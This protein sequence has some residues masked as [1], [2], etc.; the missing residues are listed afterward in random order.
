MTP[1]PQPNSTHLIPQPTSPT[2][3]SLN[4]SGRVH[5]NTVSFWLLL[6]EWT[7][8]CEDNSYPSTSKRLWR[9]YIS[10]RLTEHPQE[11]V[12]FRQRVLDHRTGVPLSDISVIAFQHISKA[13]SASSI[14]STASTQPFPSARPPSVSTASNSF[15]YQHSLKIYIPDHHQ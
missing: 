15:P 5:Y 12:P 2:I 9:E 6:T 13:T 8:E 7:L 14:V 10:V 1:Y 11:E 4:L 3:L